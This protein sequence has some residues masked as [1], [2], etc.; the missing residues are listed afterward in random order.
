MHGCRGRDLRDLSDFLL[1]ISLLRGAYRFPGS[2]VVSTDLP[3][4]T[5]NSHSACR[6]RGSSGVDDVLAC[7]QIGIRSAQED[8][9]MDMADL[10]V[11]FSD[12][13]SSLLVVLSDISADERP[14]VQRSGIWRRRGN[15]AGLR[16]LTEAFESVA[17]VGRFL[18]VFALQRIAQSFLQGFLLGERALCF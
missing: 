14:G 4:H 15:D 5:A 2:A 11:R 1:G 18:V 13:G 10:D 7:F 9:A 16:R 8:R 12:R 6:C 3:C 17:H